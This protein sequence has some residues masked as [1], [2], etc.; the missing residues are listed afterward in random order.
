MGGNGREKKERELEDKWMKTV[1][2]EHRSFH[3]EKI[4]PDPALEEKFERMSNERLCEKI[5][6]KFHDGQWVKP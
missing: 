6:Q 5:K 1:Y 2:G 4:K 3:H